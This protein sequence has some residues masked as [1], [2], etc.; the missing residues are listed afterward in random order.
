[1]STATYAQGLVNNG[2]HI[3]V[4]SGATLTVDGSSGNVQNTS[5]V[6]DL[7]GTLQLDGNLTNNAP[8]NALG[9]PT[10]GSTVV[11]AG[12]GTQA[13]GGSS[14]AIFTFDK[15]TVNSGAAL[16]MAAGKQLT[17]NGS[18]VNNGTFTLKTN[19]ENATATLLD[20]GFSGTGTNKVELY[21]SSGRNWYVSSPVSGATSSVFNTNASYPMYAYN[22]SNTNTTPWTWITDD[23]TNLN[24][25]TGYISSVQTSGIYTFTGGLINTGDK[26]FIL[27]RTV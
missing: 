12:T 17:C 6:I 9:T 25:M 26:S 4:S 3:V 2:A 14:T 27:N 15:L 10:S 19:T 7:S 21:L 5:G 18:L 13:V 11:F 22:E 1:M 8:T 16:E 23:Q 24:V 20:N